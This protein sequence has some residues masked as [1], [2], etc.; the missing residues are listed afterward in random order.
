MRD[1]ERP[2]QVAPQAMSILSTG[3]VA[4]VLAAHGDRGGGDPNATL[5]AHRDALHALGHFRCVTAGVL[6]GEPE[7]ETALNLAGQ[8]GAAAIAIYPMF[9]ADG[10]FT[11][12][13]LPERIANTGYGRASRILSPLGLDSRVPGLMLCEALS[14]A[15][16][17]GIEASSA[18]LLVVGHGSQIGPAS[19]NATRAAS[20]EIAARGMFASVATAFLE[21]P[22][23][24][25]DALMADPRPTIVSG[26][27]SGDGMHAA[28][29][30]PEAIQTT[31]ANAH[32][33]GPIGRSPELPRLISDAITAAFLPM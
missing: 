17:A 18:R 10:Y 20:H 22:D 30:V 29:D 24:L 27:F 26:F 2:M 6:K 14:A 23:F 3:D 8:S 28:E 15:V 1:D 25:D 12:K 5:R 19:A 11:N 16:R 9:M 33:A 13:V 7:F 32:Y 31:G 4:V 21:E